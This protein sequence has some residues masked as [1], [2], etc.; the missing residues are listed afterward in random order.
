MYFPV[1]VLL[2]TEFPKVQTQNRILQTRGFS[3]ALETC[4]DSAQGIPSKSENY[5]P[6]H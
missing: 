3:V 1:S 2:M 5:I 4:Q 6:L